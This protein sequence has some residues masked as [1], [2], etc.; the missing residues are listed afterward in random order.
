MQKRFQP[1]SS[2]GYRLIMKTLYLIL[3]TFAVAAVG[4]LIFAASSYFPA[5]IDFLRPHTVTLTFAAAAVRQILNFRA[6]LTSGQ[7]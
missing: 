2:I 1:M 5:A 4:P 3:I 6:I 7:K